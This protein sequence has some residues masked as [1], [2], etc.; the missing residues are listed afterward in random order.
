MQAIPAKGDIFNKDGQ[1]FLQ[2]DDV[3]TAGDF[4]LISIISID[5]VG[6]S[7]AVAEELTL[8]EWQAAKAKLNLSPAV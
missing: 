4:G 8:D 7:N 3:F 1:P 6:N 5:D 2:V